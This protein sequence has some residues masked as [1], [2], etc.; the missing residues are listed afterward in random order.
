MTLVDELIGVVD[1]VRGTVHGALGTRPYRVYLLRR[2]WDGGRPGVG[3]F[4]DVETEILPPPMVR[5]AIDKQLRPAGPEEEGNVVLTD[6]SLTFTEAELYPA[7][8][9]PA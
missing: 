4:T 1:E 3:N 7:E 2:S 8:I 9:G 6:I 5:P